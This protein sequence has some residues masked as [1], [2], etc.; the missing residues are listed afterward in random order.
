MSRPIKFILTMPRCG[1]HY[2]WSRYIQS[3]RYQLIYDA[4]RIPAFEVLS[5]CYQGKLNFLRSE[6]LNPNY[7]FQYNSQIE[8]NEVSSAKEHLAFLSK[9]YGAEAG[10]DLFE[11][12]MA[13]QDNRDRSLFSINRFIYTCSYDFLFKDFEWTIHHA[14]QALRLLHE[15]AFR[16]KGYEPQFVFI[17]RS[18]Q[19][20]MIS[21]MAMMG[22]RSLSFLERRLNDLDIILTSCQVLNIPIYAMGSVIRA[23]EEEGLEYEKIVKPLRADDI[24]AMRKEIKDGIQPLTNGSKPLRLP[25]SRFRIE[26]LIQYL[27]EKDPIKRISLVRSIGSIPLKLSKCVPFVGPRIQSDFEGVALN[28]AKIKTTLI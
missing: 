7:N 3:D 13:R 12:V 16:L 5:Q 21:Q 25:N 4:D 15:W 1:T 9:K 18:I 19:D 28:N 11:A 14:V 6:A 20:W 8:V 17:V 26:R 23:M 22:K 24:A 2:I 10:Y 27:K